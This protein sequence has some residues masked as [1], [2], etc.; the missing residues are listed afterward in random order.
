MPLC[1]GG[2]AYADREH[3][4]KVTNEISTAE[5]SQRRSKNTP[6]CEGLYP[7]EW[8]GWMENGASRTAFLDRNRTVGV[9]HFAANLER[10]VRRNA[11][12][13]RECDRERS[14]GLGRR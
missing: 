9:L 14:S 2:A 7:I 6:H 4:T 13:K 5:N 3:A 12:E 10:V 1:G 11:V 8:A